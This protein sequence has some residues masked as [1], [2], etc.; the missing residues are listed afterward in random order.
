[1]SE[2]STLRTLKTTQ[3]RPYA[4]REDTKEAMQEHVFPKLQIATHVS[5][6]SG[7]DHKY[8]KNWIL[9]PGPKD[10]LGSIP[11]AQIVLHVLDQ[12]EKGDA[13]MADALERGL[14]ERSQGSTRVYHDEKTNPAVNTDAGAGDP[15]S[16]NGLSVRGSYLR[17]QSAAAGVGMPTKQKT[18]RGGKNKRKKWRQPTLEVQGRPTR[19]TTGSTLSL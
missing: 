12:I 11:P 19:R 17:Q 8:S 9:P 16:S 14:K 4:K 3:I 2:Q 18:H 1:M 15:G 13:T 10:V 5:N 6:R 7:S